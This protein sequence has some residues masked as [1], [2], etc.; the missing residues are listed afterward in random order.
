M[1]SGGI[2][3]MFHIIWVI[4][5]PIILH[6]DRLKYGLFLIIDMLAIIYL[7]IYTQ[8]RASILQRDPVSQLSDEK[9][10]DYFVACMASWISAITLEARTIMLIKDKLKCA[11]NG[12]NR[13]YECAKT[14]IVSF[15][16][17]N[18]VL[19]MLWFCL[20]VSQN[21]TSKTSDGSLILYHLAASGAKTM[22]ALMQGV[23]LIARK[24]H[25]PLAN[26]MD[27]YFHF[28]MFLINGV[29]I[30]H[31]LYLTSFG[32]MHFYRLFLLLLDIAFRLALCVWC[33]Y[34]WC[35]YEEGEQHEQ[36]LP[37]EPE[38][39]AQSHEQ[40]LPRG[41]ERQAQLHEQDLPRGSERQAQLHEQ[42]QPPEPPGLS[43]G[44]D[45][46]LE[47][48]SSETKFKASVECTE[49]FPMKSELVHGCFRSRELKETN[50]YGNQAQIL[51]SQ[52]EANNTHIM[53][54]SQTASTS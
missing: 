51:C 16:A 42:D 13:E 3:P 26:A 33:A 32:E 9:Y 39:Q 46:P 17:T 31:S 14:V 8:M 12:R 52:T 36:D 50:R 38:R 4:L 44:S 45:L 21:I 7:V 54:N 2:D 18:S 1:P 35:C 19:V 20:D 11:Y 27:G 29:T 47:N 10:H 40:D 28:R 5:I 49:A 22:S 34:S 43:N 24:Y 15:L 25:L 37:R 48:L 6:Y 41:S 23:L 53:L 30:V